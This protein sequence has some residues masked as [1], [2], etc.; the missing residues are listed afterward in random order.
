M[1]ARFALG[2]S[3]ASYGELKASI[4]LYE[5]ETSVQLSCSD[6]RTLEAAK[7]RVPGRV[8]KARAELKYYSITYSCVFGGRA[9]KC[10][11]EGKRPNQ[12]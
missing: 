11:S 10:K 4:E 9:Y 5:R 3:F 2:Q 7:K 12:K 1:A 8:E 6:S